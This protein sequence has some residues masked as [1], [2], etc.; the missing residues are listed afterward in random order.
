MAQISNGGNVNVL[1]HLRNSMVWR[2]HDI[3][4][5]PRKLAYQ[6]PIAVLCLFG[7]CVLALGAT[8]LAYMHSLQTMH[9]LWLLHDDRVVILLGDTY[10]PEK[11][12]RNTHRCLV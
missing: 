4:G 11:R 10:S 5:G 7:Q 8:L 12:K 3:C 6:R 1:L 9:V 2:R